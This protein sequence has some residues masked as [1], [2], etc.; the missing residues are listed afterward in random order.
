[1]VKVA[2]IVGQQVVRKWG[3]SLA[4]RITGTVAEAAGFVQGLPVTTEVV[5]GGVLLRVTGS[6]RMSLAQMISAFDPV[7]H[8]A[9][10]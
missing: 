8:G 5:E 1:M 4:V 10:L 7:R 2:T 3:N 9:V 6:A